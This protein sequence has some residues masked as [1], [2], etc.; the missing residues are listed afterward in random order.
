MVA[1]AEHFKGQV[2]RS[3][4]CDLEPGFRLRCRAWAGRIIEHI[5]LPCYVLIKCREA[6]SIEKP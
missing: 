6:D 1:P 5:A 2:R 3:A 4:G